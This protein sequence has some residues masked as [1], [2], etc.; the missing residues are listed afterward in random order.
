MLGTDQPP[1]LQHSI[2]IVDDDAGVTG[3]LQELLHHHRYAVRTAT[4]GAGMRR[5]I[6]R[7]TPDLVLLDTHLPGESGHAIARQLREHHRVSIIMVTETDDLIEKVVGLEVGA[8]DCVTKPFD[9]REL[10]ARVRSVLRRA[11]TTQRLTCAPASSLSRPASDCILV[12]HCS[13]NVHA[14]RLIGSDGREVLMTAMEFDLLRVFAANPNRV[15]SRDQL[16]MHTRNRECKPFDRAI[17]ICVGRLRKKLQ[18]G[19]PGF[20]VIRTVRNM[21][22]MFVPIA[23]EMGVH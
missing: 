21:G 16:L 8:D 18:L 22:Y 23:G 12:G 6:Q 13:L 2:L 1:P 5:E 3:M 19:S 14:R 9:C 15:L 4:D 20:D 10:L 7:S 11:A 17:D